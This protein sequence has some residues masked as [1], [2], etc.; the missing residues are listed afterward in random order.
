MYIVLM[1]AAIAFATPIGPASASPLPPLSCAPFEWVKAGSYERAAM[2]THVKIRGQ[3]FN[4]QI[5]TG[6]N[7][8]ILY[9]DAADRL[10][11][12]KTEKAMVD[13]STMEVGGA[14]IAGTTLFVNRDM[15]GDDGLD[16]TLGLQ[17]LIGRVTVIDYPGKRLCIMDEAKVPD[18]LWTAPK[19]TSATLRNGKLFVPIRVGDLTLSDI[20]FDTGSSLF[21]LVVDGMPWRVFTGKTGR[22]DALHKISGSSWGKP[23]TY[24]G[25]SAKEPMALGKIDLGKPVVF[26]NREDPTGFATWPFHIDG[27]IGNAPLWDHPVVLDLT[28]HMRFGVVE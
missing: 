15:K 14:K 6:A 2:T 22:E 13:G 19:W 27:L 1:A 4:F 17:S 20:A 16:G 8:N 24:V 5:D 25:N 23:V 3:T 10:G 7:E 21:P 9:S 12:G 11:V 18:S 26:T 28:V